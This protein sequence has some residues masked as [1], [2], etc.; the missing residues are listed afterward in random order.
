MSERA[1]AHTEDPDVLCNYSAVL[2]Q[3][4]AQGALAICRQLLEAHPDMQEC[5]PESRAWR[6][7]TRPFDEAW[8]ITR[9]ASW[10][11]GKLRAARRC[12]GGVGG[13]PLQH[14]KLLVYAEQARRPD[15]VCICIPDVLARAEGCMIEW[16][17]Q[18]DFSFRA[19]V[20]VATIVSQARVMQYSQARRKRR[21]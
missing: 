21:E 3:E 5:A 15:H 14:T 4:G 10:P 13:E 8:R 17:A 9:R 1:G 12:V 2:I 7:E 6:A 20:P 16:C 18:A 19:L 11:R